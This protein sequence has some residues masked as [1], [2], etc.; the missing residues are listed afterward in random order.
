MTIGQ[1]VNF[2]AHSDDEGVDRIELVATPRYKT[3][4][5]SGDEWRVG[6]KIVFYRKGEVMHEDFRTSV[7][8][9]VA[10]L[11]YLLDLV[12]EKAPRPLWGLDEKTCAQYGCAEPAEVVLRLKQ[13]WSDRG[14]GPLP[15]RHFEQRR[16]FCRRH[17][18][19]GDCGLEDADK[20]YEQVSGPTP[21]P[22]ADDESPSAFGG[23]IELS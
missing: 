23:V 14:D 6:A 19:R 8:S 12:P 3:S 10:H 15:D 7:K 16:A 13:E 9:A 2:K 1:T 21:A 20:N 18:V 4:G 11:A 22:Q 17:A 5:L